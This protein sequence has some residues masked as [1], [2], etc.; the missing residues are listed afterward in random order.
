MT[1]YKAE[2][3]NVHGGSIRCFVKNNIESINEDITKI[4][5]EEENTGIYKS[6]YWENSFT[7][8]EESLLISFELKKLLKRLKEQGKSIVGVFASA[9]SSTILSFCDI[10]A[11]LLDFIADDAPEKQGKFSPG[12]KIP[13]LPFS[14]IKDKNPDCLLILS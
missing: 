11:D 4:I 1:L 13:I 14:A 8:K 2:K 7:F 12:K 9:K 6:D 5:Q 10:G 3:Q